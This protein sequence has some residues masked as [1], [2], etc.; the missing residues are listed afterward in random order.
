MHQMSGGV[1]FMFLRSSSRSWRLFFFLSLPSPHSSTVHLNPVRPFFSFTA[2]LFPML[3]YGD[4]LE[5]FSTLR[6]QIPIFMY[7][8]IQYGFFFGPTCFYIQRPPLMPM[9]RFFLLLLSIFLSFFFL[10]LNP[11]IT[12]VYYIRCGTYLAV[13]RH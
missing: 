13:L 6:R 8:S 1:D 12:L 9:S 11:K 4:L 5:F 10:I 2:V 7:V 3:T